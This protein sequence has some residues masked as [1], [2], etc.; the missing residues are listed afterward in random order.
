MPAVKRSVPERWRASLG[1]T[2]SDEMIARRLEREL[3][4]AY[5]DASDYLKRIEV[6]LVHKD[7]TVE[8]LRDQEFAK[9]AA[10]VDLFLDEMYEE[11]QAAR[12]RE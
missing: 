10:K 11:Y 9:A 4:T 5:G 6:R 2:P 1:P 8:M 12:T 3:K 7:I